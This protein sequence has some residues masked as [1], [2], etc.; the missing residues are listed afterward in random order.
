MP[1][2]T[3]AKPRS[4]SAV[5]QRLGVL[6]HLPGVGL[7]VVGQRLAEGHRL[8]GDHVLERAALGA[9]EH[10]L[11]DRLGVLGGAEDE[12]GA[13]AAQRLVRGAGDD[14]RVRHRRR[15][16][17]AGHQPG[18]VRHVHQEERRPTSSAMERNAAKS[19]IRA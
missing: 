10:R 9:G 17:P 8:G 15:I 4:I 14:L 2:E 6:H 11:V 19:M 13:R 18:E 12:P 7:E 1:P 16:D 3:I 5:G